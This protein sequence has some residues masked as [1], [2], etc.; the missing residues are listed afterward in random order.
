M[1]PVGGTP[2]VHMT[3]RLMRKPS[4]LPRMIDSI[5]ELSFCFRRSMIIAAKKTPLASDTR[6]PARLLSW[7][8]S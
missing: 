8:P 5:G 3:G 7:R 4:R 2:A 1:L 6:M